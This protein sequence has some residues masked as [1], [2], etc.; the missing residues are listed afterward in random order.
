MPNFVAVYTYT[1]RTIDGVRTVKS[2][3]DFE[4]A[5]SE[6]A[7]KRQ[8]LALAKKHKVE[9]FKVVQVDHYKCLHCF[10]TGMLRESGTACFCDD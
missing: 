2:I 7:V 8:L 1:S 9:D 6:L 10:D 5:T 4:N 3:K